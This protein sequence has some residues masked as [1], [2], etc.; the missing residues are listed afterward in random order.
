MKLLINEFSKTG[1]VA[2]S[3]N[4]NVKYLETDI[5]NDNQIAAMDWYVQGVEVI[6]NFRKAQTDVAPNNFEIKY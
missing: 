1:V 6:G 4:G 5:M 3:T 2:N